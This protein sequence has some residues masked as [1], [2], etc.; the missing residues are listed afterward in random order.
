MIVEARSSALPLLSLDI[1]FAVAGITKIKSA[2]RDNDMWSIFPLFFSSN[3]SSKTLFFDK[4]EIDNEVTNFFPLLVNTT[5][6]EEPFLCSILIK[7][8][9]LY[10]EIPPPMI[11]KIFLFSKLISN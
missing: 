1:K 10:A 4:D 11:S 2:H 6:T 7:S 8:R 9:D 3:I 5:L